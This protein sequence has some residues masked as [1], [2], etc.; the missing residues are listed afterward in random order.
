MVFI[1]SHQ[2]FCLFFTF[3][4]PWDCEWQG[5]TADSPDQPYTLQQV[6]P[7]SFESMCSITATLWNCSAFSLIGRHVPSALLKGHIHFSCS[8]SFELRGLSLGQ[9][10]AERTGSGVA[11]NSWFKHCTWPIHEVRYFMCWRWSD[12]VGW[13]QRVLAAILKIAHKHSDYGQCAAMKPLL[14]THLAS[15]PQLQGHSWGRY[16]PGP[17]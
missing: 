5:L 12:K 3:V 14:A 7:P 2:S 13:V 6:L 11:Q 1:A 9:A 15:C 4:Q 16:A 8:T 17:H 10:K